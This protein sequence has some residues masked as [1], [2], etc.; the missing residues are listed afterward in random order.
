VTGTGTILTSPDGVTWT[1]Q[2][3][4]NQ[5]YL[6]MVTYRRGK[7]IAEGSNFS[8]GSR[9]LLT[10]FDGIAWTAQSSGAVD[11]LFEVA[12]GNGIFVGAGGFL[13]GLGGILTSHDEVTWT[14][15]LFETSLA[16]RG[17]TFGNGSFAAVGTDSS[18]HSGAILTSSDGVTWTVQPSRNFG[19][20]SSVS[21]GNDTFVAVGAN[22]TIIQSDPLSGNCA[23][24]LSG[25]MSLLHIPVLTYSGHAYWADLTNSADARGFTVTNVGIISDI[26]PFI[27]CTPASLTGDL[28]VH[29][30]AVIF[31]G[32]SY[33]A[34]GIYDGHTKLLQVTASGKN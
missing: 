5:Y 1:T 23:A 21:Y 10:S 14:A 29:I 7:F 6:A 4:G 31:D 11:E 12:Y 33:W 24:T 9:E 25:D 18:T 28:K 17:V 3:S 2:I 8:D 26:G 22:G 13:Y 19:M 20:L 32:L 16:A 15:R 34:D 27:S 30:P